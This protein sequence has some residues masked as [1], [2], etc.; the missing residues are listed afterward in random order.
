MLTW[1][2]SIPHMSAAPDPPKNALLQN[3]WRYVACMPQLQLKD[4]VELGHMAI[5][6]SNDARIQPFRVSAPVVA[7]IIDGFTDSRGQPAEVSSLLVKDDVPE[8]MKIKLSEAVNDYRNAF[9]IA[10]IS[11][12]WQQTVGGPNPVGTL[13]SDYFDFHPAIPVPHGDGFVIQS[14]S[15]NKYDRASKFFGHLYPDLPATRHL[16]QPQADKTFLK[17]LLIAL[18]QKYRRKRVSWQM[19]ALSRSLAYAF[20]AARMPKGCDNF[21]FDFGINLGLWHAAFECLVKPRDPNLSTD[22]QLVFDLLE[23][24]EWYEPALK[25]KVG[26]KVGK[27]RTVKLNYA[28]RLYNAIRVAR[29]DFLH[30]NRVNLASIA[31]RRS[32]KTGSLTNAAPLVYQIAVEQF[33]EQSFPQPKE[34][35]SK[36]TSI[37]DYIARNRM[38]EALLTFLRGSEYDADE[39]S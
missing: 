3:G 26:V 21:L 37:A 15:M 29:N 38:S 13:F 39:E 28:Q 14:S 1:V 34:K 11:D 19:T 9:A 17:L 35:A 27:K 7:R 18:N 10:C 5:V 4:A 32:I 30:G 12:G 25:R 16:N 8:S 20:R 36:S 2:N 22:K 31:D 33:V 23:K 6:P 24:R